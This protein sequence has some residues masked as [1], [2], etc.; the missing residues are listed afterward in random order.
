MS[1]VQLFIHYFTR[2]VV[3][4]LL[5]ASPSVVAATINFNNS[6]FP[7]LTELN[8][9]GTC[10]GSWSHNFFNR[11]FTCSGQISFQSG[12]Q[13]TTNSTA[14]IILSANA[15]IS[16]SNNVI[17]SSSNRISLVSSYGQIQ[18]YGQTQLYGHIQTESGG[19]LVQ[20]TSNAARAM[21]SGNITSEAAVSVQNLNQT[22]NIQATYGTLTVTNVSLS[23]TLT[24][25]GAGAV[26]GSSL[27]GAVSIRNGLTSSASQYN[28]TLTI[29]N[30]ALNT[31]NST[32]NG[33]VIVNSNITTNNDVFLADVTSTNGSLNLTGGSVTGM[34]TTPCCALTTNNT[35]LAGGATVQSGI[36]I[37]GGTISGDYTMTSA[38]P[39]VVNNVTMTSG[40]ITSAST[41]TINNSNLGS[42]TSPVLVTS[43]SGNI[44]VNNSQVFGDLTTPGYGVVQVNGSSQVIGSCVPIDDPLYACGGVA[45]ISRESYWRF[46][47]TIWNGATNQVIDSS[48]EN[49]HGTARNSAVVAQLFPSPAS[50][51]YGDFQ[52]VGTSA[53]PFVEINRNAYFHDSDDFG[54]T[55]WLKMSAAAQATGSQTI[56]AYGGPVS[57]SSG[58]F[59][60]TRESDGDLRFSVR[61]ANNNTRFVETSGTTIFNDQW[62]HIA[63]SYSRSERRM[64]L[65]VNN[66]LVDDTP[67]SS[68]GTGNTERT[69]ND[70]TGNFAIGALPAGTSGIRGQIDEVRF[71]NRELR[72]ADVKNM[73]EQVTTC[74]NECFTEN[75]SNDTNWYLTQRNSTPPSLRTAPSRLRLTENSQNQATSI[76]FKRS[77]PAAGNKM[78]IEFDHYAYGGGTNGADGIAVVLSDAAISPVPGSYGGSLGYAQ[79]TNVN[80]TQSGFAGGWLGIG[81]DEYGSFSQATE[82]RVG[83]TT[84]RPQAIGVRAASS[85]NYSWLGGTNTLSPILS[86]TGNTL[87]RGDRYR[88]TIDSRILSPQTVSFQLERRLA[89]GTTYSTLLTSANL[90]ASGQPAPPANLLLS[91]TGSTGDNTN[92]HE[93][94]N[95]QV[96]TQQPSVPVEIGSQLH[97]IEFSY[98]ASPLTCN[99][100]EVTIKACA[101]ASCTEL[102][103]SP[104]T[105]NLATVGGSWVG[106]NAVTFTGSTTK[107]LSKT[108]PGNFTLAVTSS[109][110]QPTNA[111]Q[112]LQNGVADDCI[113]TVADS[114]FVF[115]VQDMIANQSQNV[116]IRAV[117]KDN[118]SQQCVPAFSN[119]TKPVKFWSGY[120]DP[121]AAG[122]PESRSVLLD[123]V[124]VAQSEVAAQTRNLNF[125]ASGQ[126]TVSLN[127]IDAGQMQLNARYD[128][129]GADAGL[130]MTGSD[131]FI[132]RPA[133]LCVQEGNTSVTPIS[134]ALPYANCAAYK[135]AGETF[136]LSVIAKASA[137]NGDS[138]LCS[139][140][141]S[142]PN[143]RMNTVGLSHNLLA[144][145]AADGASPGTASL[146]SYNHLAAPGGVTTVA[147][148]VSEAGV[149][150]FTAAPVTNGYFGYSIPISTSAAIGRFIPA[151]FTATP[152]PAEIPALDDC[153]NF[154]YL[155]QDMN[156]QT[157][158]TVVYEARNMQGATTLNYA[159]SFFRAGNWATD[160]TAT[161]TSY[162]DAAVD[163]SISSPVAVTRGDFSLSNQN[164]AYDGLFS[165]TLTDDVLRYL[166]PVEPEYPAP[167]LPQLKLD[168]AEDAW[169]DQDG[170]CVKT[171]D[172]GPCL[173]VQINVTAPVQ[174]YGR[175]VLKGG[176]VADAAVAPASTLV[177]LEFRTE[178][179]SGT[180]FVVNT[181][182]SCTAIDPASIS[183]DTLGLPVAGNGYKLSSGLT[184]SSA[185]SATV[186]AGL[187][188]VWPVFYAA[189][190]W[191]QYNWLE[192]TAGNPSSEFSVGR[193]RGNKRQIFWQERLN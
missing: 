9:S 63:F 66:Q 144:P 15:G 129:S 183:F 167:F 52:A 85:T 35:N 186:P 160:A 131:Q 31:S 20:G 88:I 184:G 112:C 179:W 119:T 133:G 128:G 24:T 40:T 155:G 114:G 180:A 37:T 93:I 26:T 148:S 145:L 22:G 16:A 29:S 108:T 44:T 3:A 134:C 83:G 77:F 17:G 78:T 64:R 115:D 139:N 177:P 130:V 96:C 65:Y 94:T 106:G 138:N 163:V 141:L 125:N 13:I 116:L 158:P 146:T 100:T 164:N 101:N 82:G 107:S 6:I 4:T 49:R 81:F 90:L 58:R 11:T 151:Y 161:N 123:T 174:K 69:P 162:T 19:V 124:A 189:P 113:F 185:I 159:H 70:G 173:P 18:I 53:H 102:Y 178:F 190:S 137:N 74:I 8:N 68:I 109:S 188:G 150:S 181:E 132:A 59:Q 51:T 157:N 42:D 75:F 122:R 171:S 154:H 23:G 62:Q 121:V 176:N 87:A 67:N 60:L 61:M 140:P 39:A 105:L 136:Q 110:I 165:L 32:Y 149:F 34:I 99:P 192:G 84:A 45:S 25:S 56:M 71:F 47:E 103:T 38:N 12:D 1:R 182:D 73:Y 41:V 193:Y 172:A 117:R 57:A 48:L 98:P 169:A 118:A 14:G 89:G 166:R 168:L 127:Y 153:T 80:P 135:K 54:F 7:N 170:V 191:L 120:I 152:G 143:F 10:S 111:L 97:H 156:Y 175:L 5:L 92:F 27:G 86:S 187:T 43:V 104:V 36:S 33:N 76:T 2:M 28:S 21:I 126:A 95:I 147:Q 55:L 30:G 79:R 91:Y 142:T 72:V 50:C 46:D